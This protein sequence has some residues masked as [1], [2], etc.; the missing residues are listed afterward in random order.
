[1][2]IF[3]RREAMKLE[4]TKNAKQCPWKGDITMEEVNKHRSP[5]DCWVVL[6]GDVYDMTQYILAHPGGSSRFLK[7]ADITRMFDGIHQ[8]LDLSFVEKLKIGILVA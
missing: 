4:W 8:N 2:D 5:K 3:K 6:R 1:M 7:E